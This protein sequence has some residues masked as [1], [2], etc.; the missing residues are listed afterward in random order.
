[1]KLT[2]V[3]LRRVSMPLVSPF[4]TSFGTQTARELMLLRVVTD[5]GEGWG[6]CVAMAD[7]LYSSEYND[8]AADVLRRFL[9]P[10]LAASGPL[11]AHAVATVLEP[12]KGHRMAKAALEMGVLDAE[13]R[14]QGKSFGDALGAVHD[15]V[16][17]GVSAGMLS[18]IPTETP[19]GTRSCT[20]PSSRANERPSARSSASR[21]PISSADLAIR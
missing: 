6:E 1:M 15:R 19:H 8:G 13:L 3:E 4:R 7:P 16:P 12:F 14:A 21:T 9:V 10:A 17:C 11:D 18:M 2:G 5:E 20:A